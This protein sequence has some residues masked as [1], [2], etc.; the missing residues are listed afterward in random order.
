MDLIDY[1]QQQQQQDD[2]HQSFVNFVQWIKTISPDYILSLHWIQI[3]LNVYQ[4]N[5]PNDV[6]NQLLNYGIFQIYNDDDDDDDE[7]DESNDFLESIS[8]SKSSCIK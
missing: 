7:L 1:Y 6:I 5:N 2:I 8:R 3:Y 4:V